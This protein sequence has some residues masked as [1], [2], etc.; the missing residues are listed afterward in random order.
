MR[1]IRQF[2][3]HDFEAVLTAVT[4]VLCLVFLSEFLSHIEKRPGVILDDPIL[5]V[6]PSADFSE[7][8]SLLFYANLLVF[9]LANKRRESMIYIRAISAVILV[10][11]FAMFLVPLEPPLG[12]IPLRDPIVELL[13][14]H[15]LT[16]DLFFSGH[17]SETYLMLLANRARGTRLWF[18]FCTILMP[19]LLLFQHAH[20]SVDILAA[21]FFSYGCYKISE[22]LAQHGEIYEET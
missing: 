13:T 4:L 1:K 14:G 22:R 11:S 7:I 19:V 21:F 17:T 18:L 3:R 20:Y 8:I 12:L 5:K 16:N 6:L 10:R 9:L 2:I 15:V